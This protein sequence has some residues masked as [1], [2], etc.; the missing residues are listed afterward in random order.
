MRFFCSI[1]IVL[2][3]MSATSWSQDAKQDLQKLEGTWKLVASERQGKK[4]D[5]PSKTEWIIKGNQLTVTVSGA[6]MHVGTI[7]LDPAKNP[8]E[9][10]VTYTDGVWKGFSHPALY[11]LNGDQL[12]VCRFGA[13][14]AARPKEFAGKGVNQIDY[15]ERQ[16]K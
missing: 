15:F 5:D 14:N 11:I 6:K 9:L 16:K 13:P 4:Q 7:A 3:L 10:T 2:L 12:K 1:A 8:K